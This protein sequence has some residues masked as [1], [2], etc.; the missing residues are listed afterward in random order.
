M[1]ICSLT[2]TRTAPRHFTAAAITISPSAEICRDYCGPHPR[3]RQYRSPRRHKRRSRRATRLWGLS[4]SFPDRPKRRRRR[5][6]GQRRPANKPFCVPAALFSRAACLR[7]DPGAQD[8]AHYGGRAG[9]VISSGPP[10]PNGPV[11]HCQ[12]LE[13]F[14]LAFQVQ[15][16]TSNKLPLAAWSSTSEST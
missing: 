13:V 9:I 7:P 1:P 5:P 6:A 10:L 4:P 2:A 11:G 16:R 8:S 14:V 3:R 15:P 12:P